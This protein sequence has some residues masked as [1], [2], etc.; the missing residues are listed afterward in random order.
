MPV[1]HI[2][3]AESTRARSTNYPNPFFDLANNYI[4]KNIKT[5]FKFCRSFF[6]TNGFLRN[7]ITK[8]TEYPITDLLYSTTIDE[9]T[10]DLYDQALHRKLK[11]KSLL[12]EIGLDYYTYGNAFVSTHIKSKRFI[13][14]PDGQM[15]PID[16]ATIKVKNFEFYASKQGVSDV[17]VEVVDEPIKSIDNFKLLRWAPENID[18]DYSPITGDSI[19]YYT[20]PSKIKAGIAAGNIAILRDIPLVFLD[21]LRQKKRIILDENNLFHFKRPTLAEDDMGWG[22][23]LILPALKDIYYLQTLKR[24]N[25]AISNEHIIPKKAIYPA[26][27]TTLDP[28]TQMNLGK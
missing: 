8:L 2:T 5:L 13:K 18:I 12:I 15:I 3:E 28:Y 25:E 20:I 22:K 24:G 6:Y 10:R 16:Q 23:P 9:A 14:Y 21:S 4:P 1:K 27:T 19:Y 7:V 17:K 11:I 26:N